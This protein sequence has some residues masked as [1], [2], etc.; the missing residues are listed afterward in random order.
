M[1]RFLERYTVPVFALLLLCACFAHAQPAMYV[2]GP[3]TAS[4]AALTTIYGVAAGGVVSIPWSKDKKPPALGGWDSSSGSASAGYSFTNFDAVINRQIGFGAKSVVVVLYAIDFGGSN[5]SAPNYVFTSGY[6]A[7]LS[8]TQLY[9][10]AGSDYTGSGAISQGSCAQ[11]TDNTAFPAAWMPAWET[12]WSNAVTAALTH[13]AAASYAAKIAYVRVGG[14]AGGEWFPFA[15]AVGTAGLLTV[16]G[17]PTTIAGLQTTWT[18]Y[19]STI[20]T[21]IVAAGS[22]FKFVQAVNGGFSTQAVPYSYADAEAAIASGNG[23]GI[24]DE[25]LKALDLSAYATHGNASGGSATSGYPSD[26]H[27]F[28]YSTYPAS[29]VLEFQTSAQSDPTGVSTPG[30]LVTLIPYAAG[31]GATALEL[32][33]GDWLVAFDPTN[34]N[35]PVYHVAYQGAITGTRPPTDY[36]VDCGRGSNGSVGNFD[37]PWRTPLAAAAYAVKAGDGF[38]PGDGIYFRRGCPFHDRV[39]LGAPANWAASTGYVP[40][41]YVLPDTLNGHY[42]QNAGGSCTSGSSQPS[43][44]TD[45]SAVN[46][47]SGPCVWQDMG[48]GTPNSGSIAAPIHIDSYGGW[49]SSPWSSGTFG[50]GTGAPPRFTGLLTVTNSMCKYSSAGSVGTAC[51]CQG[52]WTA[53]PPTCTSGTSHVWSARPLMDSTG[54]GDQC[55]SDGG[56]CVNCPS[57]GFAFSCFDV[58]LGVLN[59]VRFGSIYGN[60]Q[61]AA[62]NG[63]TAI[64]SALTKDRDWYFDP[65]LSTSGGHSIQT[66]WVYCTCT[67]S[68]SPDVYYGNVSPIAISNEQAPAGGGAVMLSLTG[69]QNLQIQHLLFDW[70]DGIGMLMQGNTS[71][72]VQ[73][74]VSDKITVANSA[75]QSYVENAAWRYNANSQLCA[76]PTNCA[77]TSGVEQYTQIGAWVNNN[78]G[79]NAGGFT[80]PYTSIQLLND[81]FHMNYVGVQVESGNKYPCQ[82]CSVLLENDRIYANRT[83]GVRDNVGGV[84]QLQYSHLYGNNLATA[85]ETDVQMSFNLPAGGITCSGFGEVSATWPAGEGLPGVLAAGLLITVNTGGATVL[86]PTTFQGSYHVLSQ[87]GN[88]L[89]WLMN[90]NCPA[91]SATGGSITVAAADDGGGNLPY[92]W[93]GITTASGGPNYANLTAP[94]VQGW[95]RW[96]AYVTFTYDDPGLVEYSD[97]YVAQALGIAAAKLGGAA[98]FSVAVVTGGEYSGLNVNGQEENP[99]FVAEV[100][101]WID[102]GYDVLTHSTS[103]SYWDPPA[104]SCGAAA[105]YKVPCHILDSLFYTGSIASTVTLHISHNLTTCTGLG[106]VSSSCFVITTS[107]TDSSA[108]MALDM[109]QFFPWDP[110]AAASVSTLGQLAAKLNTGP[111]ATTNCVP[112]PFY[113]VTFDAFAGDAPYALSDALDDTYSSLGTLGG[114]SLVPSGAYTGYNLD[115]LQALN[116]TEGPWDTPGEPPYFENDEMGWANT[117]VGFYL[118]GLPT[119]HV[120]VMPGTYGDSASEAIAAANGYAGVRGTGS[121]KP[122]C[123]ASTTLAQ[124]YDVFNIL[125]QGINPNFQNLTYAQMRAMMLNDG[126]KNALWG[127]PIGF[128]WHINE[129]PYDQVQ[130]MF[131]AAKQAQMTPI[132]NTA[133]VNMLLG[134]SRPLGVCAQNDSV[135]PIGVGDA[136]VSYVSGSFYACPGNGLDPDW[137][138]TINSPTVSKGATLGSQWLY[139]LNGVPHTAGLCAFGACAWDIGAYQI[140]PMG[141]GIPNGVP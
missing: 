25:G 124:G 115:F 33:Y 50:P 119:N 126:F 21:T 38:F 47:G 35:Y 102:A 85:L 40:N 80:T 69:E 77:K 6:A 22:G 60:S 118:S 14:G 127:R 90:E 141:K 48:T 66:L 67:G 121:L 94:W 110:G 101:S 71:S 128:F 78:W 73:V 107:P 27:G 9:T 74:P 31:R 29:P 99:G 91:G 116:N 23:L 106:V 108:N 58:P 132:S 4:T 39:T 49:N 103:H 75:F 125:S 133:F 41:Q 43:F 45:G 17:G 131:D 54:S 7:S 19:M 42:Y 135:P 53:S 76:S 5:T 57:A 105:V 10:C 129:L 70:Y 11:G 44:P 117:W 32:Y 36:F 138:E 13:M 15:T 34:S 46:D 89:T 130:A 137:R 65:A 92:V 86:S 52:T 18:G 12:A 72:T 112:P 55:S 63:G 140:S 68:V 26:D 109:T 56:N 122:C 61:E 111:F 20:E 113:C 134:A 24:G 93:Q 37:Q 100:Q 96:P 84:A 97:N 51:W 98:N 2:F 104:S 16:P 59:I 123:Q 81:D 139:D 136:G 8:A 62:V 87:L 82:S 30:S 120:Y 114:V 83:Y 1:K 64:A 3:P 95:Q 79:A 88:T 28:I